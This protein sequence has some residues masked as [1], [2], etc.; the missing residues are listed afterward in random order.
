MKMVRDFINYVLILYLDL[1]NN[2]I[3]VD[4]WGFSDKIK[5]Y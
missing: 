3:D 5:R 2:I 4:I 1:M